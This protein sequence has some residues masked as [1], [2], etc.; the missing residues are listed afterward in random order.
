LSTVNREKTTKIGY[1]SDIMR[2]PLTTLAI[3]LV[4][5]IPGLASAQTATLQNLIANLLILVNGYI[6]PLLLAIAFISFLINIFRFFIL[7]GSNEES[8]ANAKY[9]A[10]YSIG[11]FVFIISLWG[12]V[13]LLIGGVFGDSSTVTSPCKRDTIADYISRDWSG[14]CAP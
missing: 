13:N 3:G 6:I 5:T 8:Q 9:L 14:P 2:F 11:A 1:D 10:I 12:I 7:G 4:A